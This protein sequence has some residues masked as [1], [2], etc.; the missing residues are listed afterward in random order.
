MVFCCSWCVPVSDML[1]CVNTCHSVL[2]LHP[3]A[4]HAAPMLPSCCLDMPCSHTRTLGVL[5][6][7]P[8][9]CARA[10]AAA[11]LPL[12]CLP[13]C[14]K[15]AAHLHGLAEQPA[16]PGV[17][18]PSP[19]AHPQRRR[20]HRARALDGAGPSDA[21]R[22][23]RLHPRS[24][25]CPEVPEQQQQAHHKAGCCGHH[26]GSLLL[27]DGGLHPAVPAVRRH[28]PDPSHLHR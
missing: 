16:V 7:R 13:G 8:P 12:V 28:Q 14:C 3:H 9:P 10:A 20:A 23:S 27:H 25:C 17:Q 18:P 2:L 1:F 24:C 6:T 11:A 19:Q 4:Q 5:L 21:P 22:A 26:G 15:Q